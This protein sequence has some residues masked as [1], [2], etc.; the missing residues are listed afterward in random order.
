MSEHKLTRYYLTAEVPGCDCCGILIKETEAVGWGDWVKAKDCEKL[1]KVCDDLHEACEAAES[2]LL[3]ARRIL[4]VVTSN[5][6]GTDNRA[7]DILHKMCS[8]E[9]TA[10]LTEA[11]ALLGAAIKKSDELTP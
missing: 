10:E 4:N 7:L 5:C 11:T 9:S 2:A 1:E 3:A 8:V 6:A